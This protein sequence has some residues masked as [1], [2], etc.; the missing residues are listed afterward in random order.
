MHLRTGPLNYLFM[1]TGEA[2]AYCLGV[3]DNGAAGTLLG[4]ISF[5]NVLVQYDRRARRVGLGA[6]ACQD[7]GA[8]HAPCP[9]P[10]GGAGH[11]FI[12]QC[13]PVSDPLFYLGS[14]SMG[15]GLLCAGGA[16]R[17]PADAA[18]CAAGARPRVRPPA[19][20]CWRAVGL[21]S[22]CVPCRRRP[23]DQSPPRAPGAP[24]PCC[25]GKGSERGVGRG[26]GDSMHVCCLPQ[27]YCAIA[28][29]CWPDRARLRRIG[30]RCHRSRGVKSHHSQNKHHARKLVL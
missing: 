27:N 6:A 28:V 11:E 10:A 19:P 25:S 30:H 26:K 15:G 24:T 4:G 12:E 7:I 17:P 16:P 5:R 18:S 14:C 2:G 13:A 9:V 21:S 20:A 29:C 23:A 1:H 3:F 22:A 8:A